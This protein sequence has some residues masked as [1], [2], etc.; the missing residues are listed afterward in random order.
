MT[1]GGSK[2]AD[3]TAGEISMTEYVICLFKSIDTHAAL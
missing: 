2:D 3:S 1:Q